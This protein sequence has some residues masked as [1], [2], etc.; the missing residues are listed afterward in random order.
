M[1][2]VFIRGVP[3]GAMSSRSSGIY[4][5]PVSL[6][7][8]CTLAFG[9]ILRVILTPLSRRLNG[10]AGGYILRRDEFAPGFPFAFA[11]DPDGYGIEIWYE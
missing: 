11:S 10:P 9:Y 3:A 5:Q 8:S 4:L 2:P 1:I 7:A 6:A